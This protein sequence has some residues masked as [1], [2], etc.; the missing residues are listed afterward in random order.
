M[1]VNVIETAK[2][3]LNYIFILLIIENNFSKAKFKYSVLNYL[4]FNFEIFI[5]ILFK[6]CISF[7]IRTK[8]IT[9]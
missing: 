4:N 3:L 1:P 5:L 6:G 2:I 7:I 9:R 8:Y